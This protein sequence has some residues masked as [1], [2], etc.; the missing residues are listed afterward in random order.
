VK[1]KWLTAMA[2]VIIL[3][4]AGIWYAKQLISEKI[5]DEIT[6]N[7]ETVDVNKE[8]EK[9]QASELEKIV[10]GVQVPQ[11]SSAGDVLSKNGG[12]TGRAG[13]AANSTGQAG[14]GKNAVAPIVVEA[15][16][17]SSSSPSPNSQVSPSNSGSASTS[18]QVKNRSE[19]IAYAQ[20][21]FSTQ[22]IVHYTAVYA[23]RAK[24]SAEEKARIKAE[25]LSRFTSEEIRMLSAAA[26]K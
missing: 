20:K 15:S 5:Y 22:E 14:E 21:K 1:R 24:L 8:I 18:T 2:A 11:Q 26:S 13:E 10:S 7:L 9:L 23:N 3:L 16:T 19:A 6:K 4:G 12:S 25:I 17:P